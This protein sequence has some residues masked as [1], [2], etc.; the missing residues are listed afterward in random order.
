MS[1][2]YAGLPDHQFWRRAVSRIEPFRLDPVIAT[3]FTIAP[4]DR[5]AT[6]GS[7]F[8]QHIARSLRQA[9]GNYY[10]AEAPPAGLTE[11]QA[12]ELNYAVFSARYGNIYTARQLLQLFQEAHGKRQPHEAAWQ[13]PDGRFVDPYRPQIEPAGFACVAD[14]AASRAAHLAKVRTMFANAEIFIFTLGLTEAWRSAVD[15]AVF[16]LAP[17][18]AGGQIDAARHEFVNFTAAEV[19][20]DLRAFLA[21]L[22]SVNPVCRVIL[23]VSP[24]PLIATYEARHVLVSTTYSK[25]ALRVAAENVLRGFPNVEYFPSYEI[26]T[27]AFNR[28]A[29]YEDDLR[30]VTRFGVDHAMRVF[31]RHYTQQGGTVARAPAPAAAAPREVEDG[32]EVVCDEEAIDQVRLPEL[33]EAPAPR[34]AGGWLSHLFQRRK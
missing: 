28:G 2:P 30:D 15:G 16:P 14:V 5:V 34:Q 19:E 22:A 29:Y 12:G 25:S 13:R 23:T 17:G 8:A 7:C 18:V 4:T 6:A 1:S 10:V 11:Q 9:G 26:I 24:V 32:Y 33:A 21:G 3:R 27:G 31:L 20:A